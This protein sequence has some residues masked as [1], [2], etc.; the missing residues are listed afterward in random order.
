VIYHLVPTSL[1]GNEDITLLHTFYLD[2]EPLQLV[3]AGLM[4]AN[5]P[6]MKSAIEWF[7]NGPL[8]KGFARYNSDFW[9][10]P[11]LVHEMSSC[12]P[13]CSW[14][15]FYDHQLGDRYHFLEGM[16]SQYAGAI[17]RQ[18]KTICESRGGITGGITHADAPFI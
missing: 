17:S 4:E 13:G 9:Q 8:K 14:N 7:R 18:T 3:F 10:T 12:I 16:Y 6:L 15:L 5:D 1:H 2:T 11:F